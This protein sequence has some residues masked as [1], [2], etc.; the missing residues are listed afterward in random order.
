MKIYLKSIFTIMLVFV[1]IVGLFAS[2]SSNINDVNDP[3]TSD[4]KTSSDSS[5]DSN[6]VLDDLPERDFGGEDFVIYTREERKYEFLAEELNEE[7]INDK[8]YERNAAVE[9][10]FKVIIKTK[11]EPGEEWGGG[12][13]EN[14]INSIR[15]QING[16]TA[17]FDVIAGYAAIIPSVVA[18]GLFYNWYDI[19]NVNF[20]KNYWS[21]DLIKQLT[22]NNRMFLL[23]GDIA[24]SMW[25]SLQGIYFNK[26]EAENSS[27]GNLYQMV[28]DKQWT[29][30]KMVSISKSVSRNEDGVETWTENDF[31]GY[32]TAKTTQVDVYL[33]AFN[34]PVTS[35]TEDG[36]I[37]TVNCAKTHDTLFKLHDFL[38]IDNSSYSNFSYTTESM[39]M[40]AEG[41]GLFTPDALQAGETLKNYDIEY[42]ILP[43][44]LYDENQEKYNTTCQDYFSLFVVPN[45]SL[46]TEFIGFM[47]EAL[48]SESSKSVV[49]Q[50]Y[51]TILK[52]RY[53]HDDDSKNMIDIIRE[54][55]LFNFGYLYS[56][57]MDW[58]AHQLNMILRTGSTGFE[59]TWQANES[60]F[61][62]NLEKVLAPYYN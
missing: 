49:N 27:I 42:G 5:M 54:G 35:K 25:Q 29:Y 26:T 36:L 2:C 9:E 11:S 38:N 46:D 3:S 21:Q 61:N 57:S 31:Y 22:V 53:T 50:Y 62:S 43:M 10:R 30:D 56:Y 51:E 14:F 12:V 6:A 41:K 40:F 52:S 18:E 23:T 44:P 45:T 60:K 16:G 8:I 4:S 47:M 20:N 17:N 32:I 59:A 55:V 13:H 19:E 28:Y 1:I 37:F 58:P 33:D 7:F 39:K 15:T 48:C 24:L 34:I